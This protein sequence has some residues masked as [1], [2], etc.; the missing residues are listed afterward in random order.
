MPAIRI[1]TY[2]LFEWTGYWRPR[3]RDVPHR[4][5]ENWD[6]DDPRTDVQTTVVKGILITTERDTDEPKR[7]T[8]GQRSGVQMARQTRRR[9]NQ[10]T[11]DKWPGV[12]T[13]KEDMYKRPENRGTGNQRKRVAR[14]K[15]HGYKGPENRVTDGQSTEVQMARERRYIT[16]QLEKRGRDEEGLGSRTNTPLTEPNFPSL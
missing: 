12:Q 2:R 13:P 3:N 1:Q 10:G 4:R 7:D 14:A 15:G 9:Y 5:L 11:G 16:L 6:A 8:D